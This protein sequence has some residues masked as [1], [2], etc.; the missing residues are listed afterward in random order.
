MIRRNL[1]AAAS[2][3]LFALGLALS[4][5]TQPAKVVA[6]LDVFGSWDPS[7]AFVMIGAIGVHMAFALRARRPDA[8]PLL[9]ERFSLPRSTRLDAR[10]VGGAALFGLGWGAAGFCPGPAVVSLL[11][12][13]ANTLLFVGAMLVGMASYEFTM[14]RRTRAKRDLPMD[15]AP[16]TSDLTA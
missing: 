7:L 12:L 14:E 2:G 9:V 3:S 13:S 15:D 10:L 6:F 5:M 8:R 16:H 1:V 4:G 11:A